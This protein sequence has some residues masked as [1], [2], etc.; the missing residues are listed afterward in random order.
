MPFDAPARV[1]ARAEQAAENVRYDLRIA[2]PV[3]AFEVARLLDMEVHL[4]R[5]IEQRGFTNPKR[6]L[7]WVKDG[8][9]DVRMEHA[10]AHEIGHHHV[11]DQRSQMLEE[12]C[13]R[14]AAALLLPAEEFASS[15]LELDCDP[16][17]LERVWCYSSLEKITRRLGEVVPGVITAKWLEYSTRWRAPARPAR[18]LAKL[19]LE[20]VGDAYLRP[21]G[22]AMV[23]GR[24][25]VARV[26][27]T[28]SGPRRA[29]SVL[30]VA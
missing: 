27:R 7:I 1:L 13:N 26:W 3:S 30:Q 12:A 18:G 23:E 29:V 21:K 8:E 28:S 22:H 25:G 20:A 9:R 6:P 17:A 16:R 15:A 5:H 11:L 24:A 10:C 2:G 4:D 14:F 19:E